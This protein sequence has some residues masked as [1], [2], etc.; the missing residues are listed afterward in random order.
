MKLRISFFF[1]LI[2]SLP[3]FGQNKEVSFWKKYIDDDVTELKLQNL[4]NADYHTA[5]RLWNPYQVVELI[6]INDSIYHGQLVNFVTKVNRKEERKG[7]VSQRLTIPATVTKTL[8]EQLLKEGVEEL[9]DSYDVEGYVNG[10]D[11]TTYVFEV[12]SHDKYRVYSYWEPENDH[13]Q[14]PELKEV[15]SVRNIISAINKQFDSWKLFTAFRDNLPA[16][17]YQYG[18]IIMVVSK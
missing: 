1:L 3:L 9:P 4:E 18:G 7:I 6:S 13:Y 11:G 15:K 5:I 12:S 8:I 10:L 14:N 16:G 17:R 2:V